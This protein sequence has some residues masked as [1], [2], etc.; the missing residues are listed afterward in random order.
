MA[1]CRWRR[2]VSPPFCLLLP[3]KERINNFW[4]WLCIFREALVVV[5]AA[6]MEA[7]VVII[8]EA[9]GREAR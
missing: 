8:R 1:F 5:A 9:V 7:G 4:V 3:A 2:N 6:E